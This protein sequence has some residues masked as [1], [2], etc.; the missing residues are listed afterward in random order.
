MKKNRQKNTA[1]GAGAHEH[2]LNIR[3]RER[4]EKY[5]IWN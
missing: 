1:D 5:L 2:L 4:E 3:R